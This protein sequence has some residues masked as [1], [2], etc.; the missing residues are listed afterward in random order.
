MP[1]PAQTMLD[2]TLQARALG[3]TLCY[4]RSTMDQEGLHFRQFDPSPPLPPPPPPTDAPKMP[5]SEQ[6]IPKPQLRGLLNSAIKRN[7]LVAIVLTIISGVTWKIGVCDARMKRYAD[8]YRTYDAEAD[9]Q[10][11]KNAGVF[12]SCGP[13]DD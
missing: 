8:F 13:N 12:T 5:N 4:A 3:Q 11:M 9:F 10:R 2:P 6:R 1:M 7:L